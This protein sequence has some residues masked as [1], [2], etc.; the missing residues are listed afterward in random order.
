MSDI[1]QQDPPEN[2]E[3]IAEITESQIIIKESGALSYKIKVS[4]G[5]K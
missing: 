3:G 2:Q 4:E 1:E 5:P